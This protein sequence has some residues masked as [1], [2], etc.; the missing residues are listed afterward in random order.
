MPESIT[1]QWIEQCGESMIRPDELVVNQ[2]IGKW[3]VQYSMCIHTRM[4]KFRFGLIQF[5]R[6]SRDSAWLLFF[7]TFWH[8]CRSRFFLFSFFHDLILVLT[9]LRYTCS[10]FDSNRFRKCDVP[11]FRKRGRKLSDPQYSW[12]VKLYGRVVHHGGE[13][14]KTVGR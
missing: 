8:N 4:F 2:V 6:N 3:V 12:T 1:T 9:Y 14:D 13:E 7:L 11:K 5:L 10:R